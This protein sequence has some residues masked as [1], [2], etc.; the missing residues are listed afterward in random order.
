M[1]SRSAFQARALFSTVASPIRDD[2]LF[3]IVDE[4]DRVIGTAPRSRCHGDPSLVHR[5]AH[6]LV[7][8]QAGQLLLQKRSG[9]KQIQPGRWDSSVG[10]HLEPGEDYRGAAIRE[11]EEELGL[12]KVPVTFLFHSQIRNAVESENVATFLALHE[13]PFNFCQ[14]EISE[15]RFWSSQ[16]IETAMG[17]GELTPN[18]EEEWRRYLSWRRN[19]LGNTE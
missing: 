15:V 10:G 3:E 4:Q 17:S 14:R 1:P 8:N 11:M 6:V 13:G 5:A 12:C 18:F 16:Q 2:E 9:D 7:I 19:D